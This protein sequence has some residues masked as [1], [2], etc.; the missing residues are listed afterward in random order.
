MDNIDVAG[1]YRG[2]DRYC[3]S[4]SSTYILPVKSNGKVGPRR[5]PLAMANEPPVGFKSNASI[6]EFT[7]AKNVVPHLPQ[8]AEIVALG[9]YVCD[10]IPAGSEIFV[11]YGNQYDRRHYA[12]PFGARRVVGDPCC[13]P[14]E[15]ERETPME[16]MAALGIDIED[17]CFA[18]LV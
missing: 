11:H 6:K 18:G 3:I 16:M 14:L 9:F 1:E 5:Y 15:K 7:R 12:T 8:K 17:D 4:G 2:K 13:P 10:F